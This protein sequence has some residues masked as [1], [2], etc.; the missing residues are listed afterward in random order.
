MTRR[1]QQILK[2]AAHTSC[3]AT[4]AV[5]TQGGSATR[6]AVHLG[7]AT[8]LVA[9]MVV[10]A[11][12]PAH[13]RTEIAP[14]VEVRQT[15][16]DNFA[17]TGLITTVSG[18]IEASAQSKRVSAFFD[19]DFERR[20]G[21]D[22]PVFDKSRV[23]ALARGNFIVV[24]D[25]LSV[26]AGGVATRLVRDFRGPISNNP[27]SNINNFEDVYGFYVAPTI[28]QDLGKIANLAVGYRFS[29]TEVNNP[30]NR[31]D[32]GDA[33]IPGQ[34]LSLARASDSVEHSAFARLSNYNQSSRLS[35]SLN[36]SYSINDQDFLNEELESYSGILDAEYAFNRNFSLLGSVGYE[37]I[38]NTRDSILSDPVT[39]VPILDADGQFQVDP[40]NPRNTTY[41]QDGFIWDAGF[42]F[43]PGRKTNL[44]VRGGE[45]YGDVVWSGILNYAARPGL[46]LTAS[47]NESIDTFGRLLTQN[48]AGTPTTRT[49]GSTSNAG[50]FPVFGTLNGQQSFLGF[51]AVNNAT[52]AI[53]RASIGFDLARGRNSLTTSVFYQ[54]RR[55]LSFVPLESQPDS[56]QPGN[57]GDE[58]RS[59]GFTMDGT[60]RASP[61]LSIN[62]SAFYSNLKYQLSFDRE[63][64]FYGAQLGAEYRLDKRF[65]L[66][67]RNYVGRR[68]SNRQTTIDDNEVSIT[69]G[70]RA[71]F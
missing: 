3:P 24:R 48:L 31:F 11:A 33:G 44:V 29:L 18:G 64:H 22:T 66:F 57:I 26:D 14:R 30:G 49:I 21:I 41:E 39:F 63:D 19:A 47:Y 5:T 32:A 2:K 65:T 68:D 37:D 62:Y 46:N 1:S 35:W 6:A 38:V 60:Y 54:T 15:W 36:G 23:N 56:L 52:F 70:A 16:S 10:P 4:V 51:Q 34:D 61:A 27:D 55:V 67:T 50:L 9:T 43:S 45:R 28:T 40:A 53:K 12:A 59:I 7:S 17:G 71:R 20:L 42:R 58:D 13:A 25:L 69:V 8:A